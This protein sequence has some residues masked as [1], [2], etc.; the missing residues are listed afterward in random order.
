MFELYVRTNGGVQL[1]AIIL[2]ILQYLTILKRLKK[3]LQFIDRQYIIIK[4]LKKGLGYGHDSTRNYQV[5][6]NLHTCL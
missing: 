6:D 4:S 1:Y 3:V 5:V 2:G